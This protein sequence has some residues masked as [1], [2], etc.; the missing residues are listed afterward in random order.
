MRW[1]PLGVMSPG[2]NVS[3]KA[4]RV[5]RSVLRYVA[6]GD[7]LTE[8]LGDRGFEIDRD[9]CGWADRLATLFARSA[10]ETG[11]IVEFA[12][13]AIRSRT[14]VSIFG[15]QVDRALGMQPDL[16]TI[17]AGAN[18]LWRPGARL[19]VVEELVRSAV[20]RFQRVGTRVVLANTI[21]PVHHWAFRPGIARS[22]RLSALL[23]RLAREYGLQL[24]DVHGS[25]SLRRQ[26]F[27][28]DDMVHFGE[29]GHIHVANRAAKLLGIPYQLTVPSFD[30]PPRDFQ[31]PGELC[32][33]LWNHVVP[34]T[35]RVLRRVTAGDGVAAKHDD[36]VV[37][38]A[39]RWP[40]RRVSSTI[41]RKTAETPRRSPV[42]ELV[43]RA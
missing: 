10:A 7:S 35:S 12:N 33:W 13:L 27:W 39:D 40:S 25:V 3:R 42:D 14:S 29:R 4:K 1:L 9:G 5:T 2:V 38:R 23:N 41:E 8:G 26:R 15:E 37:A 30:S 21:N 28:A 19:D 43:A 17:M 32:R 36:Y 20:E 34:F 24:L 11:G 16:V 6:L 31:T 18:D 22:L